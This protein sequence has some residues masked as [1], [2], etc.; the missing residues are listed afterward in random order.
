MEA[1]KYIQWR[2]IYSGEEGYV[3]MIRKTQKCFINTTDKQNAHKYRSETDARD[4]VSV[5]IE[6]GEGRNNIFMIVE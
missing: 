5:L 6:I 1:F 3:Q 4:A 2:N